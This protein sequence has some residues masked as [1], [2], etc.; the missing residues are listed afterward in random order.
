MPDPGF[1]PVFGRFK[2]PFDPEVQEAILLPCQ[3]CKIFRLKETGKQGSIIPQNSL[4]DKHMEQNL[5]VA[6]GA[7][8]CSSPRLGHF[9]I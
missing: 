2:I 7:K 9:C 3:K 6:V 1:K 5:N 4:F 8:M